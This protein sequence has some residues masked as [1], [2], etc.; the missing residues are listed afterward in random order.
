MMSWVRKSNSGSRNAFSALALRAV[1]ITSYWV[2]STEASLAATQPAYLY[3]ANVHSQDISAFLINADGTLT[4]VPGSPFVAGSGTQFGENGPDGVAVD[5]SQRFLYVAHAGGNIFAFAINAS[6]GALVGV[7]GSPFPDPRSPHGIVVDPSGKYVYVGDWSSG[8]VSAFTMDQQTGALAAIP[9]SPFPTGPFPQF[10]LAF[11]NEHLLYVPNSN[12]GGAGSVSGFSVD[13]QTGVLTDVPGS[14]FSAGSAPDWV[15]IH[16]SRKFIYVMDGFSSPY[17]YGFA[18]DENTGSLMPLAWSP[19]NTTYPANHSGVVDASGRFLFTA[20]ERDHRV[21][22]FSIDPNTGALTP[23]SGSPYSFDADPNRVIIDPSGQYVYVLFGA[24]NKIEAFRIDPVTASLS[25]IPGGTYSTGDG[26][27]D[28]A[29]A[30]PTPSS[31]LNVQ[32]FTPTRGGNAGQVTM[33]IVGS[34]FQG[35]TTVKLTGSGPDIVG[36][37]TVIPNASALT[38]T[39]DLTGAAPGVR[40]VAVTNPD[41]TSV[42]LPNGFTVEQGGVPEVWASI[43][44]RNQIRIGTPQT[45]YVSYGNRGNRDAL[46]T[47]LY[48]YIPASL[49]PDLTLGNTSGVIASRTQDALTTFMINIGRAAANSTSFIP[50]NLTAGPTQAPFNIRVHISSR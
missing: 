34:G 44:G 10:N 49:A 13:P 38:T 20:H 22:I 26:P 32:F 3:T 11:L 9:G 29:I 28:L 35:G 5:P 15:A 41:S 1:L 36:A 12:Q 2:I 37:N 31:T 19:I 33:Q 21:S 17:I 50:V 40:T 27:A 24:V 14:P 25:P 46:G 47:Q 39:F 43:L 7:P 23:A 42:T 30:T 4:A 16:P 45:F 8:A 18:A 48:I 6:N